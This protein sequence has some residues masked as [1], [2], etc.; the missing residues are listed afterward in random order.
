MPSEHG[1][2]LQSIFA[3]KIAHFVKSAEKF[4]SAPLTK[5]CTR[6]LRTTMLY[7]AVFGKH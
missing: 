5:K 2:F 7:E 6:V 1:Y 4:L 3:M